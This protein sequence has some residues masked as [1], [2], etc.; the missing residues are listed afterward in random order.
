MPTSRKPEI[1]Q[2]L[3]GLLDKR[4]EPLILRGSKEAQSTRRHHGPAEVLRSG[5]GHTLCRQLLILPERYFP[6]QL[7]AIQI[8]RIQRSPRWTRSGVALL[9]Q[10]QLVGDIHCVPNRHQFTISWIILCGRQLSLLINGK[11]IFDDGI[12]L[13]RS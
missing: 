2:N 12:P 1:P 7:S 4:P 9:V 3:T 11:E 10:K 8:D 5:Y 13:F 6:D